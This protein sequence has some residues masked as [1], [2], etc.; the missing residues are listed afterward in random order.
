MRAIVQRVTSAKVTINGQTEGEIGKGLLVLLGITASDN[1]KIIKWM[2]NKIANLRIFPD[3]DNKMNRSVL[4]INGGILIISNFTL[5]GDTRKGFRPS[6]VHAA[7]PEIAEPL[8]EGI[9]R[10][11]REHY[12]VK[13]ASGIFGAILSIKTG[14]C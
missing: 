12:P 1:D 3:E 10:Y 2:C 6:F 4:D 8:F 11:L 13:I 14:I 9:V 5:Y 7:P